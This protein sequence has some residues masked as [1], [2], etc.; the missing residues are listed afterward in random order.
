[1]AVQVDV[2]NQEV[3]FGHLLSPSRPTSFVTTP[4][5]RRRGAIPNKL[6]QLRRRRLIRRIRNAAGA[7]C[8]LAGSGALLLMVLGGLA[9]LR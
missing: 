8:W 6:Q 9:S 3:S 2:R 4:S 1:M 5:D 7:A